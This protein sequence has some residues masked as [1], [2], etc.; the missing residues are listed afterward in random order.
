MPRNW[1]SLA[2]VCAAAVILCISLL[3]LYWDYTLLSHLE[4]G[5]SRTAALQQIW[6]VWFRATLSVIW[7]ATPACAGLDLCCRCRAVLWTSLTVLLASGPNL[8]L[9]GL[10]GCVSNAVLPADI[11]VFAWVCESSAI[12]LLPLFLWAGVFLMS[13]VSTWAFFSL[14]LSPYTPY[15]HPSYRPP[16]WTHIRTHSSRAILLELNSEE[17]CSICLGKFRVGESLQVLN[18]CGHKFHAECLEG[19]VRYGVSCPVCRRDIE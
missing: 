4:S 18:G 6:R 15:S 13:L 12:S 9:L 19:W 17:L 2:V 1:V 11:C 16:D 5:L 10:L 3:L 7:F 8:F 14:L